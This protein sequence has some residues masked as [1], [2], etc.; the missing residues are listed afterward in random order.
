MSSSR[1]AVVV[2]MI[3]IGSIVIPTVDYSPRGYRGGGGGGPPD[4][5]WQKLHRKIFIFLFVVFGLPFLAVMFNLF[6]NGEDIT[7]VPK[8]AELV[9]TR[10]EIEGKYHSPYVRFRLKWPGENNVDTWEDSDHF[11]ATRCPNPAVGTQA[12]VWY[13]HHVY[14]R[15]GEHDYYTTSGAHA[16]CKVGQV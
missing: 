5:Y 14:K 7:Q 3:V 1:G 2:G 6:W 16:F 4:D 13:E 9:S 11:D 10:I 12:N 8:K 15:N